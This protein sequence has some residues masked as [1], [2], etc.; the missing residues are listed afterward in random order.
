MAQYTLGLILDALN[1]KDVKVIDKYIK[2]TRY[3]EFLELVV[4]PTY[5]IFDI[6]I[7]EIFRKNLIPNLP[8]KGVP[9]IENLSCFS[10]GSLEYIVEKVPSVEIGSPKLRKSRGIR[11]ICIR[12]YATEGMVK[13]NRDERNKDIKR[14]ILKNTFLHMLPSYFFKRLSHLYQNNLSSNIS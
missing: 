6:R 10:Y 3:G 4:A 2:P 14:K 5:G 1:R 7:L 9:F 8:I 13:W 12:I 11:E